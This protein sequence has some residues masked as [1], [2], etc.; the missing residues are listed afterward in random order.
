MITEIYSNSRI[1]ER[2]SIEI[3]ILLTLQERLHINC[4][5]LRT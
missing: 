3:D 1:T 4:K 5:A 2:L